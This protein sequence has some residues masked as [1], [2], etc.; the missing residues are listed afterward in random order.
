MPFLI[1]PILGQGLDGDLV[2]SADTVDSPIDSAFTGAAGAITGSGTNASFAQGQ[3]VLIHQ[4]QGTGVFQSER[5][6]ISSYSSGT[7][8]FAIPL[9]HTY[10]AG[11]QI[12]VIKQYR[13]ITINTG[14]TWSAKP[15]NG[16][17]GGILT[18]TCSG[19]RI[20][21][22]TISALGK[23]Y[24][25]GAGGTNSSGSRSG[26]QGEGSTG[27]GI[28]SRNANN[29]GGG[30]GDNSVNSSGGVSGG[31]GGGHATNGGDGSG[32][33]DIALSGFAG[34]G[35]TD[36]TDGSTFG[37]GGG[38]GGAAN[39]DG[40]T[41]ANAGAGGGIIM[42]WEYYYDTSAGYETANGKAGDNGG[43]SGSGGGGGGGAAGYIQHFCVYGVNGT[44]RMTAVG[45]VGGTGNAA[46]GAT[47]GNGGNGA[48]GYIAIAKGMIVDSGTTTPTFY[49]K[50]YQTYC[51]ILG[52]G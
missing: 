17:T 29:E 23:G 31:G 10:T 14:V 21:L 30:G 2:I 44:N 50:G 19:R 25:G 6:Y 3:A 51:G 28:V 22:G 45:G 41:Q 7:I 37:F 24:R 36:A 38:G 33:S 43:G 27:F 1:T 49:D 42:S 12:L 13:S 40:G 9:S 4:S 5:N 39:D 34:G 11:A 16:T 35:A 15:W 48:N 20:N 47:G 52:R 46:F 26:H 18:W 8:N 32:G